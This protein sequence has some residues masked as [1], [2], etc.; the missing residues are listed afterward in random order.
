MLLLACVHSLKRIKYFTCKKIS[1][2]AYPDDAP[3]LVV[4]T[5]SLTDLKSGIPDSDAITAANFRPNIVIET[6]KPWDEVYMLTF[7]MEKTNF[8]FLNLYTG[9]FF[10]NNKKK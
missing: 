6:D 3:I 1:Q 10:Y 2:V 7:I 8:C 9:C 5:A 4:N